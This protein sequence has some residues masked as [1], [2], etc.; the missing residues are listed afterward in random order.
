MATAVLGHAVKEVE[1]AYLREDPPEPRRPYMERWATFL[2]FPS[3]V[4]STPSVPLLPPFFRP[5]P[6]RRRK[7]HIRLGLGSARCDNGEE[8]G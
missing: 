6:L 7:H 3:P 1:Q 5:A 8:H 2:G 4:T